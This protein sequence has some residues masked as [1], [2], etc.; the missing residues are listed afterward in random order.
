MKTDAELEREIRE[1]LRLDPAVQQTNIGVTVER[2]VVRLQGTVP[3]PSEQWEAERIAQGLEGVR[4]VINHLE[5]EP[6]VV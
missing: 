5:V 6:A 3:S 4:A 2:G 1:A